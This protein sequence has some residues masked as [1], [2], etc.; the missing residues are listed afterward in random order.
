MKLKKISAACAIAAT[1]LFGASAHAQV[2]GD[3]I[4]IGFIT[5]MSSLYADIDGPG[6]VEAIKMAIAD[7]GGAIN[8]KKVELVVADHQNKPDIGAVKA[9][10]WFD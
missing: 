1:T 4:R 10:E 5:D 8:G 7:M 9:R 6:G 2:S 3:V